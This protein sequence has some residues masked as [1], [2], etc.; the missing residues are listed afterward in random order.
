M[1][2]RVALPWKHRYL[3]GGSAYYIRPCPSRAVPWIEVWG[4]GGN[5]GRYYDYS[6]YGLHTVNFDGCDS[7][8]QALSRVDSSLRKQGIY[9]L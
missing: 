3:D 8:T 9:L 2:L 5:E 1:S 6:W 4:D 7:I